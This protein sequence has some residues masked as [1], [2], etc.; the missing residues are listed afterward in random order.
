MMESVH[1]VVNFYNASYHSPPHSINTYMGHFTL[2]LKKKKEN[3]S[4]AEISAPRNNMTTILGFA[5]P[6]RAPLQDVQ[7]KPVYKTTGPECLAWRK[8]LLKVNT[9]LANLITPPSSPT[10]LSEKDD[11]NCPDSISMQD[12]G[13]SPLQTP[14]PTI[15][16]S[17]HRMS[18]TSLHLFKTHR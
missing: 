10:G 18:L 7:S 16:T 1:H 15:P 11:T 14:S 12:R 6:Q 2:N 8:P 13:P 9:Q 17:Q 5:S 4:L 3:G